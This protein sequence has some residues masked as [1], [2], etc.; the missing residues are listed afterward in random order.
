MNERN[1]EFYESGAGMAYNLLKN[2]GGNPYIASE[3][4]H[5]LDELDRERNTSREINWEM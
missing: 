1:R 3:L 2:S 5:E 4:I